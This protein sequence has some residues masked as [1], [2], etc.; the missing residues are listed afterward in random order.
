MYVTYKDVEYYRA[1]I[2]PN[3]CFGNGD[4]TAYV[5][6][7]KSVAELVTKFN[8]NLY[9]GQ[10]TLNVFANGKVTLTKTYYDERKEEWKEEEV[11]TLTEAEYEGI[12]LV[13][14]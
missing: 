12:E 7:N 10:A 3:A 4:R 13:E 5:L 14:A 9:G 2:W 11:R 6:T 8:A 1:R